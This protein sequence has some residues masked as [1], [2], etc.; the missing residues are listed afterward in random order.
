MSSMLR[1]LKALPADRSGA[2]AILLAIA[3]IPLSIAALGAVDVSRAFSTKTQLQDALDA[4][5]L[6]GAREPTDDINEIRRV[7]KIAFDQN[8]VN[9]PF[10]VTAG[11]VFNLKDNNRVVEGDAS[12]TVDTILAHLV[13]NGQ[14]MRVNAHSEV[15]RAGANLE[16]AL[17]LDVTGS[18]NNPPSKMAALK[19]A[20]TELVDIVVADR[21]T[22]FFSKIAL[23][24]YSSAVRLG[25]KAATVRGDLT[26]GVARI[27]DGQGS[28][29]SEYA[30]R[31]DKIEFP[32]LY[33]S[34]PR[35]T[36]HATPCVTERTADKHEYDDVS[37]RTAF[38]GRHYAP[39]TR[40]SD[41]LSA[42][43]MPLTSSKTA[44]KDS[45]ARL[46]PQGST[47]GHIGLAWG[48]YMVS[49]NWADL[50]TGEG[51]AKPY[52]TPDLVKV[53]VL[54]TDGEFNTIYRYGVVAKDSLPGSPR[55]QIND[56][57]DNGSNR[58]QALELCKNMKKKDVVVYTVGFQLVEP[59]AIEIMEK[60]AT[61]GEHAYL[62]DSGLELR[63][64]FRA[65]GHDIARLHISR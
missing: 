17:V 36:F 4:A 49:P 56:N 42:Q 22:P 25:D 23:V 61:S 40:A 26:N 62:P 18:M 63:E 11:P 5:T 43:V 64:A 41:C 9:A 44:L 39:A 45:I 24:P 19:A 28:D 6:A 32:A 1:R 65:I 10:E 38:V 59:T 14:D 3:V 15:R 55:P 35:E 58:K 30:A 7:A 60:C 54:M 31:F 46:Q 48:W 47:A 52:N 50:W 21:Q 2:V 37:Y 34:Q 12:A 53:V 16:V 57:S 51:Q 8:R 27:G 20:A 29:K 33:G 13:L